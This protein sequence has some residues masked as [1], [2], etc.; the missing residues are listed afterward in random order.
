MTSSPSPASPRG[1]SGA[2]RRAPLISYFVIAFLGSW[3]VWLPW[4]LSDEAW[5]VLHYRVPFDNMV[6]VGASTFT[7]PF[8]GAVVV[9]AVTE[10]RGGVARFFRRFV[11]WRVGG[12]W[13]VLALFGLPVFATLGALAIPGVVVSFTPIDPLPTAVGYVWFFV[14]P[15]TIIGG[16]LGEEPG[17]RGFAQERIQAR[18][19]PLLGT[20]V[21]GVL[22][23]VWHA[24]IWFSGQWTVPSWQ[25][26]VAFTVWITAVSVFY[27]WV[28][29]RSGGSI[30]IA[31]LIHSAMDAF[32]NFVL[33]PMFPQLGT[34]TASGV[35]NAYYANVIG[36]GI[37]A[38]IVIVATKGRLGM[39]RVAVGADRPGVTRV[40]DSR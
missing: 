1:L 3:L 9:T 8:L 4:N 33:F 2:I 40:A 16:P 6:I 34:M 21:L 12:R 11:R 18:F 14:W 10:G 29:N 30:L 15:V 24:T 38:I 13:Y 37:L 31:I 20:I 36:Y 35:L 39:D 26:M 22:W 23:G 7:G 28:C 27:T 25:N 19:G 5:G 32:P 17:W